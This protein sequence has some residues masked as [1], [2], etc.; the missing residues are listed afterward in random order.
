VPVEAHL[1]GQVGGRV[2]AGGEHTLLVG[3]DHLGVLGA[4]GVHPVHLELLGQ[5]ADRRLVGRSDLDH[6]PAGVGGG[7][8]DV[9]LDEPVVGP[10]VEDQV[11]HLGQDQRIDDVPLDLEGLDL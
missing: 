9:H 3:L 4:D 7:L 6:G 8:A 1:G 5:A 11:E 2:E 10:G